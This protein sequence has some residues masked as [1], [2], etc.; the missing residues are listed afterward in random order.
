[1]PLRILSRNM[2]CHETSRHN[3]QGL[4][5]ALSRRKARNMACHYEKQTWPRL[6]CFAMLLVRYTHIH[7]YT[8]T[9]ILA[10]IYT[11]ILAHIYLHIYTCT[12]I[13]TYTCTY[14]HIYLL[15]SWWCVMWVLC[16]AM[17][18]DVAPMWWYAP[19]SSLVCYVR[20]C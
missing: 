5:Y 13:H 20:Q 9:Y 2:H 14:T 19:P 8:C 7:T 6:V 11:H 4:K 3:Y 15:C 17:R 12:H 10:P 1:M 16:G 18:S